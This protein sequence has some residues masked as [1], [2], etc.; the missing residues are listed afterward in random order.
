MTTPLTPGTPPSG[1][2]AAPAHAGAG[3]PPTPPTSPA[4]PACG[5]KPW[6]RRKKHS[7]RVR[8]WQR[9]DEGI[10]EATRDLAKAV[11]EAVCTWRDE[12]RKSQKRRKD[13]ALKD[14]LRNAGKALGE[15]LER[16]AEAPKDMT[17]GWKIS[18]K[19]LRRLFRF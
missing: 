17:D 11:D 8:D 2:G 5:G 12:S 18:R 4:I 7:R 13:G 3:G 15:G 9:L 10:S 19:R 16:A 1:P 6:K 14:V